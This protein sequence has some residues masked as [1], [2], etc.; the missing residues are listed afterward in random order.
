[1]KMKKSI[2]TILT[3]TAI[4]LSL[5]GPTLYKPVTAADSETWFT[6]MNGVLTSDTYLLYPYEYNSLDFG[7]SKFG[8]MIDGTDGLPDVGLQYPGY[9]V[10]GT[11]D[12]RDGTSRDPF[13]NEE[14]T[15]NLWLNGWLLEARY[16]HRT[17]RDRRDLAMAMFADMSS[18]EGDWLNG[19]PLPLESIPWGG[20][21]TTGYAETEDLQVLYY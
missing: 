12:Q 18:F 11:Y 10:V 19:H 5:L 15:K 17:K 13:A 9:E 21:K 20:R 8:E 4:L 7:L 6:T 3:A 2:M 14:I 1:M 16:T